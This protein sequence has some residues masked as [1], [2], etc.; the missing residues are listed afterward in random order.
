M[1][2]TGN[3]TQCACLRYHSSYKLCICLSQRDAVFAVI[4]KDIDGLRG[5]SHDTL[6]L[7]LK[8][9]IKKTAFKTCLTQFQLL[10]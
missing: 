8:F 10:L 6:N 1:T 9:L 5:L 3:A 4:S 7:I 2:G